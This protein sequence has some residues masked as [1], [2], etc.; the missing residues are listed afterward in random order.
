[1]HGG[2]VNLEEIEI[3]GFWWNVGRAGRDQV[4]K[5]TM[6]AF[7]LAKINRIFQDKCLPTYFRKGISNCSRLPPPSLSLSTDC[8]YCSTRSVFTWKRNHGVLGNTTACVWVEAHLTLH[9]SV[10]LCESAQ[11]IKWTENCASFRFNDYNNKF[12]RLPSF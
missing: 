2:R 5:N 6:A 8:Q 9:H 10:W 3:A 4:P 7:C 11:R 1:M 12:T